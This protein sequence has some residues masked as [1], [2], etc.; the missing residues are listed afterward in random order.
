MDLEKHLGEQLARL[1]GLL[2]EL[3]RDLDLL[4]G[5]RPL[6]VPAA[7]ERLAKAGRLAGAVREEGSRAAREAGGGGID[8]QGREGARGQGAR[9]ARRLAARSRAVPR[10]LERELAGGSVTHRRQ[11]R[12]QE[13]EQLRQEALAEVRKALQADEPVA[14]PALGEPDHWLSAA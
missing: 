11:H 6:D 13:L 4:R 8:W 10:P 5:A 1:D 7:A 2:A 3:A 9:L 12:Q 14:L